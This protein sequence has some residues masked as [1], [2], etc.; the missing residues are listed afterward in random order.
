MRNRKKPFEAMKTALFALLGFFVN[1]EGFAQSGSGKLEEAVSTDR[2]Q[3]VGLTFTR[4]GRM[5][6]SF[7]KWSDVYQYGVVEVMKDG[8]RRP[9][10]NEEWNRWDANAPRD[11][12]ISAQAVVV[13]ADDNLWILDPANPNLGKA[14]PA[15]VKLLKVDSKTN[16]VAQTYRFED[17]PLDKAAL[18]DVQVDARRQVAYLSDPGRAA[19]VVLDL[20][21]G[22]SRTLLEKHSSTRAD[23]SFV[24]TIDGKAVRDQSGK[25]FS[26]HV[27]GIALTADGT[28]L[29]FRPI[30]QPRLFR[31]PTEMLRNA[32][33][34]PAE[35]GG[36][37]E[38][39][40]LVGV[41]HG[42]LADAAGNVY[43]GDSQDKTIRRYTPSGKLETLVTD[44]RLLWPDSFAVG[45]DG[46]L[47]VTAAQYHRLPKW[48]GG[49]NKVTLPFWV[50]KVKL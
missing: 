33:L 50:F 28:Y 27:N 13:D 23:S 37:V 31:I 7:P 16:Q 24:L 45:P 18:N 15:G 42:M 35:V 48:N 36:Q 3:P 32:N 12:F 22:K 44:A 29:Y 9:F 43:L 30:T 46:F 26:S 40:G 34:S 8:S 39:L 2:Y 10:P 38:A 25:P 6:V 14:I 41:S 1:A 17:L 20:K 5:F 19:I 11:H 47:Y 49:E 4:S 21:T